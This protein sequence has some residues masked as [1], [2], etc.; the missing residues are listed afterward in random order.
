[1]FMTEN[2]GWIVT[3]S[4]DRPI[5][6]ISKDLRDAGFSVDRVLEEIGSITGS[7]SED[8]LPKIR[9]IRGVVDVSPD[10]PID[11]GPPDSKE[12]W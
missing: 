11:I 1:M 6:E 7:A 8:T 5:S 9:S 4:A 3:T 12:T 10:L 2:K